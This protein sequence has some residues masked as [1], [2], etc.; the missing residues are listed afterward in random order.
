MSEQSETSVRPL[1]VRLAAGMMIGGAAMAMGAVEA[2][3][4][5]IEGRWFT[6]MKETVRIVPCGNSW[7]ATVVTGAYSGASVGVFAGGNGSYSAKMT[8][9]KNGRSINAKAKLSGDT[10]RIEGC[11]AAIACAKRN[12]R[13]L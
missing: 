9:P 4:D 2:M 13:R 1:A 7:C 3:A 11:M 10:L 6:P 5:P 12:W 8:E